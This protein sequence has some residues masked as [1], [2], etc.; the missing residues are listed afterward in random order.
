MLSPEL[1]Q[2]IKDI[3]IRTHRLVNESLAGTYHSAFRGQ[4]MEFEEVR[5][6]LPG[7]DV[8]SID[9]NVSARMNFPYIKKYREEREITVMIVVDLSPSGEFGT[10]DRFKNEL[11]AE[12]AAILAYTAIRNNDNVGLLVFSGAIEHFIPPGKGRSHIYRVIKEI[13]TIKPKHHAENKTDI[14]GALQYLTK[15]VRRKAICFLIS[16][17]IDANDLQ[18]PLTLTNKR[19][20]LIAVSITDPREIRLPDV[21]FIEFEDAET[22]E[23]VL[24]DTADLNLRAHFETSSDADMETRDDMFRRCDVDHI[25]I[26]TDQPII[27][28]IRRFF[29]QRSHF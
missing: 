20:D 26:R 1:V 4:G 7:D 13:L 21:G 19:H 10:T 24:I 29:R 16:D 5:E 3:Q 6:Y 17:F 27:D 8:R 18:Q 14:P 23:V 28:P 11:A 15:V 25:P 12:I 2:Q 9:W 22:G